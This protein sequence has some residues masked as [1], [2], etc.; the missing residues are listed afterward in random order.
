VVVGGGGLPRQTLIAVS[1]P[2]LFK[3]SGHGHFYLGPHHYH[4]H[5]PSSIDQREP[6]WVIPSHSERRRM[7]TRPAICAAS[8]RKRKDRYVPV[9][10]MCGL[11]DAGRLVSWPDVNLPGGWLLNSWRV[12]MS[13]VLR[14]GPKRRDEIRR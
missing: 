6:P 12:P 5:F 14:E 1:M 8:R 9:D 10:Y 13:P 11:Y 3:P 2:F 7:T 4:C